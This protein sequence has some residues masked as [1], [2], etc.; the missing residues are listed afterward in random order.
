MTRVFTASARR[1]IALAA[2]LAVL[3][4]AG[5]CFGSF[6]ITRKVYN[7]NKSA[8]PNKWVRW[9]LFMGMNIIPV[10]PAAATGDILFANSVEFWTGS[11]PVV[12]RL[13]PK[14][15]LAPD[16]GLAQLLPLENGA[17][18]VLTEASGT[19]HRM[20]LL[21]EAPGVVAV[22]REDGTLAGKVVGVGGD[23]PRVLEVAQ[24][25]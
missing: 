9:C 20:T 2:L 10:Y 7:F 6:H 1:S 16:G 8:T 14:T 3:P 21:R 15:V 19:V 13:E 17:R 12:V 25:R 18:I 24:T 22:Y 4:L 5:G 11:N 23:A